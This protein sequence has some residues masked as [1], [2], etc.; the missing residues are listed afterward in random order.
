VPRVAFALLE[1]APR[2]ES[3]SIAEL[4]GFVARAVDLT[5]EW[6]RLQAPRPEPSGFGPKFEARIV[7]AACHAAVLA[8]EVEPFRKLAREL[9]SGSRIAALSAASGPFFSTLRRLGLTAEAGEVLTRFERPAKFGPT[10]LGCATGYFAAGAEVEGNRILNKAR[11]RLFVIGIAD[12]RDRTAMALAYAASLA[13]APPRMAL[14]RLE[15]IFLRLEGVTAT[16]ATNRYYTLKPLELVDAVVRAVA[17]DDFAVGPL[18]RGW[19]DDD[20]FAIRK[21][22]VRDLEAGLS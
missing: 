10:D 12:V 17:S 7:V 16:G 20:E 2:L 8:R 13:H 3:A 14:G 1:I 6:L 9:S 18:V 19:L 11:E 15:E 22:I 21:R 5:P 4:L